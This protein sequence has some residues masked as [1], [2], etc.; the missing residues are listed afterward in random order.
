MTRIN[1]SVKPK[2][3]TDSMLNAELRE[4]PRIFT[5]VQ[6]RVSE[7]KPFNDIPSRF[8]LGTGHVLLKI[9]TFISVYSYLHPRKWILG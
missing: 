1:S 6:K 4:L 7:N 2:N 9:Y 8:T 3:L 5:A